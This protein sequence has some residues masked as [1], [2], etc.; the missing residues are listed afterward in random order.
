MSS[1]VVGG[2]D[3]V[4]TLIA[5]PVMVG[6][7]IAV[8]AP[9]AGGYAIYKTGKAIYDEL[10]R[11][12]Q[13]ALERQVKEQAQARVRLENAQKVRNEIIE[14]CNHKIVELK[15]GDYWKDKSLSS[16]AQHILSE[17]QS[18]A[19]RSEK[20]DVVNIEIQNKRDIQRIKDLV[21]KLKTE[22]ALI[23]KNSTENLKMI[24]FVEKM[25]SLFNGLIINEY[26]YI[27]NIE[28]EDKEK[29]IIK[30]LLTRIDELT[31]NFYV[32]V[33]REVDR[34]GNYPI[35]SVDINRISTIFEKISKEIQSINNMEV[36]PWILE[37]KIHSIEKNIDAYYTY[38]SLLD[39]EQEKFLSLYLCYK[40][41]CEKVGEEYKEAVEFDSLE[42]LESTIK[43]RMRMLERAKKCSEIY[44]RIGRD[45]YIC[46]AFE[47]ELNALN[48]KST[49][50]REAERI[51][52]KKLNNYR[53]MDKLCPFYNYEEDSKMQIFKVNDEVGVQL[54]IHSDGTSTME[55]ISLKLSDEQKVVGAQRKHCD[56]SK[57]L[58]E[59]LAKKWFITANFDEE[60]SANH[61]AL[62]FGY[63]VN[64]VENIVVSTREKAKDRREIARK[65]RRR[66]NFEK[67]QA[68]SMSLRY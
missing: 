7:A 18:I 58:E 59:A 29:V 15:E 35:A 49:D 62:E 44:S 1:Y 23:S 27:H 28:I 40:Q 45:A 5:G 22:S 13:E 30:K 31:E 12:H 61:I 50:K 8:L 32:I 2:V 46:M 56:R 37:E 20:R 19:N 38:K 57:K 68:R 11:E 36:E 43:E 24:S 52:N 42:E 67:A 64:N 66:N 47:T 55:T 39:K 9:V 48:Y 51:L 21:D 14:E 54:I 53:V 6:T 25:E 60:K 26:F 65:Q 16:L 63:K 4:G 41:S 33:G 3:V 34:F 17:L 10:V